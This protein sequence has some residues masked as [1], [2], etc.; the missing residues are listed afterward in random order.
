V[1]WKLE[2][3]TYVAWTVWWESRK[4]RDGVWEND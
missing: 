4:R 1:S 3:G 2:L